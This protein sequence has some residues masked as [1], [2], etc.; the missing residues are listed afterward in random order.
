[1]FA[2]SFDFPT[3][4]LVAHAKTLILNPEILDLLLSD[5]QLHGH[6]VP[7]LLSS[8]F[9]TFEN[10]LVHLNLLFALLHAHFQLVLSV[11]QA[12]NMVCFHIDSVSQV[13]YLKFHDVML[14]QGFL[15][16][17]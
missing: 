14:N 7:F 1:M 3:G 17:L 5:L 16:D 10:I 11:F 13:L 9:F 8:L 15:L 2:V 6:L 4:R 12:I